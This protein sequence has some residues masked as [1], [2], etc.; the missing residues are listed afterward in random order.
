[1]CC[2]QKEDQQGAGQN[3]AFTVIDD[4]IMVGDFSKSY[5]LFPNPEAAATRR[6]LVSKQSHVAVICG[7]HNTAEQWAD[8]PTQHR[9]HLQ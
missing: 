6:N 3:T 4:L 9:K 1:M 8:H 2:L 7:S 5:P